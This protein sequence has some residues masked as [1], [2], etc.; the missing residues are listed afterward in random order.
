M[1]VHRFKN[2]LILS[3]GGFYGD[4]VLPCCHGYIGK[5]HL[6]I[7]RGLGLYKHTVYI[8]RHFR[9]VGKYR[10]IPF[11]GAA[12]H[13][14][15]R[16]N[17]Y[18][19][20]FAPPGPV[21][22]EGILFDLPIKG[23]QT[24]AVQTLDTAFISG[25]CRKVEHIPHMGCPQIGSLGKG[26]Q[27]FLVIKYGIFFRIVMVKRLGA[28]PMGHM[29]RTVLRNAICQIRIGG[30]EIIETRTVILHRICVPA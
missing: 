19:G 22:I 10:N 4:P 7:H 20:F 1:V 5:Y 24:L 21:H 30:M 17:M 11:L 14:P 9:L 6:M 25:I 3:L 28:M 16:A 26:F 18:H 27:H 8:Q 23:H 29:I 12:A 15:L 13:K 2:S